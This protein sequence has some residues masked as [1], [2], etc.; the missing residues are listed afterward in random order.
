MNA[1][2]RA[3]LNVRVLK[4][5][6]GS[7]DWHAARVGVCTASMFS[8][9]RIRPTRAPNAA[10]GFTAKA[11]AYAFRL[12]C[13]RISGRML[14][15]GAEFETWAMRRGHE[16]EPE[17]RNEHQVQAGVIVEPAGFVVTEDGKFGASADGFL[18]GE[19][20]G[21]EYKCLVDP[22]RI[23]TVLLAGDLAEFLDQIQGGMWLTGLP[24]W[25]FALY[26]PS[27]ADIGGP[28]YWRVIERDEAYI[29]ALE[30]DLLRFDRYVTELEQ[31]LRRVQWMPAAD[32]ATTTDT[33]PW[34]TAV[35]AKPAA[36]IPAA[37]F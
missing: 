30:Q 25:H 19:L 17:A 12:A 7:P 34:E 33:P 27:L 29:E 26:V 23:S 37:A 18:V 22:E 14:Q 2:D 35:A 21:A 5:P 6:Q 32:A 1:I 24:R 8:E 10:I 15:E 20:A 4:V 3:A 31:K 16:L 28:L 36:G 13:E 11:Q 9:V